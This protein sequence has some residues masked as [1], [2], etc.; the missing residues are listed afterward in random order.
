MNILVA[1]M[2]L[3]QTENI[4]TSYPVFG[5]KEPGLY[6]DKRVNTVTDK[7]LVRE[8]IVQCVNDQE[9]I[10]VHDTIANEFCD[11]GNRCHARLST[12]ISRTCNGAQN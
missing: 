10:L 7:G 1:A 11:S 9:G 3:L 4:Y 2:M 6:T 8:L 5:D 12:A